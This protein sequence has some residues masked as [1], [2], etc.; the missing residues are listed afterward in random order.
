MDKLLTY[1]E[2]RRKRYGHINKNVAPSSVYYIIG[3]TIIRIS[4]HIKYGED[5]IRKFDYCF[6]IQ[7]NGLYVFTASPKHNIDRTSKMYL[8]IVTFEEAK[9]FIKKIHDDK[10]SI[11]NMLTVYSPGGWSGITNG[12]KMKFEDFKK[13]YIDPSSPT[14]QLNIVDLIE[15]SVTGSFSK[16]NFQAKIGGVK[17]YYDS[18]DK[19]QVDDVLEKVFKM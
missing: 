9:S 1:I 16:G 7:D 17:K 6:I 10:I 15:S 5:G 13:K 8:K 14:T 3:G 2:N 19:T 18:L 12:A 4:D 11:N